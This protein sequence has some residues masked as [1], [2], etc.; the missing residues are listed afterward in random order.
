MLA[1]S[2]VSRHWRR[3]A[4]AVAG[5]LT[6]FALGAVGQPPIPEEEVKDFDKTKLKRFPVEADPIVVK[7]KAPD[8]TFGTPPDVKLDELARAAQETPH[9]AFKDLYAKHTYPFDRLTAR[10]APSRI[11]P[12]PLGRGEKFPNPFGV[13]EVGAEGQLGPPVAV[14]VPDVQKIE[15]FEEIVLKAGND[16]LALKPF[17]TGTGAGAGP[18]GWTIPDQLSAAERVMAAALRFHDYARENPRDR[19][20]RKGRGWDDVRKPLADRLREVRLLLLKNAVAVGDWDRVRQ[21]GSQLMAAYPKDPTV[22]AEVASARVLEARRLLASD[23]HFDHVKAKDLLDEFDARYPGGG[24]EPVKALRARIAELAQKAF[25]RARDKKAVN[26]LVTARDAL[27]QAA[28]LDP[29]IPGVREMQRELKAG[30]QT[31]YVGVRDFPRNMTPITARLDSE[32]QAV[33]LLFEGLLSEVPDDATGTRYRPGAAVNMPAVVIGGR[34]F[35]LR[36]QERDSSGRYGFESHDVVSTLK[37]LQG[38]PET[39]SAYALPWLDDLP[40]PRDNTGVRIAFRQGHPDPRALLTF[41]LLP[42]RWLESNGKPIDDAAFAEKP[43]GTGPFKLQYGTRSDGGPREMVFVDNPLYGRWRDRANQ[44][45]IKEVR[46][47]EV[48]KVYNVVE[49]F[50]QGSLHILPDVPTADLDKFRNA[51]GARAEIVTAATNRRVHMLAVN[52]RRPQMRSKV[53]RQ[54]LMM[55]I[56]REAILNEVFR[57]GKPEFHRSMNGPFPPNS[58]AAPKG[59]DGVPTPLVNRDLAVLKL[60]TYLGDT[61]AKAEVTLAYP[62]GDPQSKLACEAIQKQIDGLFKDSP[63]RKLAVVLEPVPLRDLLTRVEDEHRFDLAYVPFDYPDDWYPYA[64]GAMLEP[65]AAERGGRNWF[66]FLS[67][68]SGADDQDARLGQLLN[69]LRAFREFGQL[70]TR[71]AEVH[72]Q[73]N[74]CVPFIPLWQLDRHMLVHNAVKVVVDD[75]D[76]Q[77]SPKVLNPTTLFQGIARWRLE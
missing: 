64:L 11:K 68:D 62:D 67:R 73:F 21:T 40:T 31:L 47:V 45:F 23:K 1:R 49:A 20:G 70:A 38:K 66:G 58:W 29:T 28:A 65:A 61:G 72:K 59:A 9:P 77:V 18:A 42:A 46:L 33:E 14:N 57:A 53:L 17:G 43:Y 7:S 75:S 39:W 54:G 2:R 13:Q 24:G 35:L 48:A 26:D 71:S 44:P 41:K 8:V 63:G 52:H 55:A 37:M 5:L 15:Y 12:L 56:D 27:A 51:L 25:Q 69:D 22:A 16:L 3:P 36:T 50:Q 76:A 4:A 34:E 60:K 74:E 6:A 19:P 10:G 30:Y 32:K